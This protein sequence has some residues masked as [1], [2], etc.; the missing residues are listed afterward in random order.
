MN[1]FFPAYSSSFYVALDL[2][3]NDIKNILTCSFVSSSSLPLFI[4]KI[5]NVLN[6]TAP[7]LPSLLPEFQILK[8]IKG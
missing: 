5:L 1:N 7:L 3:Q 2:L 8:I 6:T 4:F